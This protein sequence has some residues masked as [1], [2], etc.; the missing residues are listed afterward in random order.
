ME[1]RFAADR[2]LGKLAK[3]LRII[4]YDT[5]YEPE[6]SCRC[7]FEYLQEGRILIT[8]TEKLKQKFANH[9]LVFITS[10][11]LVEQLKQVVEDVGISL[12]DIRPF[13]RCLQCNL[14][15]VDVNKDD[16]FC[17]VPSYIWENHDE[18]HMC[19]QC[20]RIYWP[21]SHAERSMQIIRKLFN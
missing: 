8:R 1:L 14:P 5:I 16:V 11:Y 9:K 2:T 17:L 15:I 7:F 6:V 3:W 19:N 21:G 13:S 4:G 12:A 20:E 18:F 10:N